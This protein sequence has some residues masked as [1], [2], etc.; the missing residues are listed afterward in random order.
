MTELARLEFVKLG[1]PALR[2][3]SSEGTGDKLLHAGRSP[4]LS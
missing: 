1:E 2:A 3:A 4:P